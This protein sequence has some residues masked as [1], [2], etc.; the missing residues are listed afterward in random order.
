MKLI[1]NK[2]GLRIIAPESSDYV[3]YSVLRNTYCDKVFLG[4]ND[5]VD[6]YKEIEKRLIEQPEDNNKMQELLDKIEKQ[7]AL[8][9]KLAEQLA[10]LTKLINEK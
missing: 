4:K 1:E 6:N 2:N 3:I 10:E 8:I 7:D 9:S 5:S